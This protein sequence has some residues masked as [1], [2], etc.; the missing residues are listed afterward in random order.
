MLFPFV[1]IIACVSCLFALVFAGAPVLAD[2]SGDVVIELPEV[3]A[4][5]L[6]SGSK[7]LEQDVL[8]LIDGFGDG[9]QIDV[10]GLA[11]SVATERAAAR[12]TAMRR[13]LALDL[14]GDRALS[15]IEL[16]LAGEAAALSAVSEERAAERLALMAFDQDR[17]GWLTREEL[18]MVLSAAT[19][20]A[21]PGGGEGA[22]AGADDGI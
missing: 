2:P 9:G 12:A 14:D 16:R 22:K 3:L 8:E 19:A 13:F 15:L 7:R 18:R 21:P 6:S 17:D 20:A 1:R 10:A 4:D 11:L 5:A